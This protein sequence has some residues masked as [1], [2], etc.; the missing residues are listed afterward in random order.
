MIS[1]WDCA[2]QEGLPLFM[3]APNLKLKPVPFSVRSL[4][5]HI[6]SV[7]EYRNT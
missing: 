5:L 7:R 3:D 4:H 6:D 2:R 1:S